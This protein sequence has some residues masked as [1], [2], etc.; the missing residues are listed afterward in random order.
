LKYSS[1]FPSR[2]VLA[3]YWQSKLLPLRGLVQIA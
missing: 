3:R 1:G 2:P